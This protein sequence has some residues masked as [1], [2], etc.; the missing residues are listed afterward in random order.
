MV[1]RSTT[2]AW[3]CDRID[4]YHRRNPGQMIAQMLFQVVPPPTVSFPNTEY[5]PQALRR[6]PTQQVDQRTMVGPTRADPPSQQSHLRPE[7][8]SITQSS[9]QNSYTSRSKN[10]GQVDSEAARQAQHNDMFRPQETQAVSQE[11]RQ[12]LAAL[13]MIGEV[14]DPPTKEARRRKEA[15]AAA[16]A[17]HMPAAFAAIAHTSSANET[18]R[19]DPSEAYLCKE[20]EDTNQADIGIAIAAESSALRA[21][22]PIGDSRDKKGIPITQQTSNE[23]SALALQPDSSRQEDVGT[24]P[25]P[26]ADSD[27]RQSRSLFLPISHTI[28]APCQSVPTLSFLGARAPL[29]FSASLQ[30]KPIVPKIHSRLKTKLLDHCPLDPHR[31]ED[32][33][34][35]AR[36]TPRSQACAPLI[37]PPRDVYP[38]CIPPPD[39]SSSFQV[40]PEAGPT[41]PPAQEHPLST[42]PSTAS[43]AQVHE[44]RPSAPPSL[45]PRDVFSP[46]ISALGSLLPSKEAP[47]TIET[48]PQAQ[49]RIQVD[50]VPKTPRLPCPAD[51][52]LVQHPRHVPPPS[53]PEQTSSLP[54]PVVPAHFPQFPPTSQSFQLARHGA[55]SLTTALASQDSA[56]LVPP[57]RDIVSLSTQPTDAPPS[58]QVPPQAAPAFPPILECLPIVKVVPVTP[59]QVHADWQPTP[60]TPTPRDDFLPQMPALASPLRSKQAQHIVEAFP[61]AQA[62]SQAD[63]APQT[64]RS[65]CL[66]DAHFVPPPHHSPPPPIPAHTSILPDPPFPTANLVVRRAVVLPKRQ[67]DLARIKASAELKHSMPT[68]S[69]SS[70]ILEEAKDGRTDRLCNSSKNSGG[71]ERVSISQ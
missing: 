39:V 69:D 49:A 34:D 20:E 60:P 30:H 29:T 57:P 18:A 45:C 6:S 41:F 37:P 26:Q 70:D 25:P 44:V 43:T 48:F 65:S 21:I 67:E 33:F 12:E 51:A 5:Q 47:Y 28:F 68:G 4:E 27:F 53:I 64:S 40:L 14:L 19:A 11:V 50:P 1:P 9:H 31:I 8:V 54:A 66:D 32:I 42:R 15:I 35:A 63:L 22:P 38:P 71:T 46:Q 10:V 56:P 3:L 55:A 7:I 59:A 24:T 16:A 2:V 23:A 52:C 61:L 13:M 17:Q 62:D 36:Y 58:F